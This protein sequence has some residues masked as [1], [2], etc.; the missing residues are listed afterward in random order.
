MNKILDVP[1]FYRV[2]DDKFS[3]FISLRTVI[4]LSKGKKDLFCIKINKIR[5]TT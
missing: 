4:K 1:N 2:F 5:R 3:A